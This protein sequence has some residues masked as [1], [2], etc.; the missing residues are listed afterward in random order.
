MDEPAPHGTQ[1]SILPATPPPPT[2][3]CDA[4]NI[5]IYARRHKE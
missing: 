1:S 5:T 3:G 2:R 4:Q